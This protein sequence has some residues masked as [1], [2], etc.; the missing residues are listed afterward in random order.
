MLY[1]VQTTS[2][3]GKPVKVFDGN[4]NEIEYCTMVDMDTEDVEV[5]RRDASGQFVLT[6]ERD[7]IARDV[8]TVPGVRV[9]PIRK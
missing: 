6:P 3:A 9:E 5:F 7:A 8:L 1:T 2:G 4:G